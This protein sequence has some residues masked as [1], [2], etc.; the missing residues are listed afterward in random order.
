MVM[1]KLG[2]QIKVL[3]KR[4]KREETKE[5]IKVRVLINGLPR[6]ESEREKKCGIFQKHIN[7]LV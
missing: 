7:D 5:V 3:Y 4:V 2:L 6:L 1:G